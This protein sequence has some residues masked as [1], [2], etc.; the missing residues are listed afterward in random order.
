MYYLFD[1]LCLSVAS[2]KVSNTSLH[3]DREV[4]GLE[5]DSVALGYRWSMCRTG[6]VHI[7]YR[8]KSTNTVAHKCQPS[9]K[10]LAH[11]TYITTTSQ[12]N[13]ITL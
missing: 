1:H 3:I 2:D 7:L 5:S 12:H 8:L 13:Y 10:S 6:A 4:N 9:F 11:H